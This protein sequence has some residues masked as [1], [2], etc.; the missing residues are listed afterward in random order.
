MKFNN[1]QKSGVNDSMSQKNK[2][3]WKDLGNI[4]SFE[5]TMHCM[6]SRHFTFDFYEQWFFVC[7]KNKKKEN[8]W[9]AQILVSLYWYNPQGNKS[10]AYEWALKSIR[11]ESTFIFTVTREPSAKCG[12][13]C[14]TDWGFNCDSRKIESDLK[15]PE[16]ECQAFVMLVWG[17]K[18]NSSV[19]S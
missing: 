7:Y 6:N 16:E 4:E 3:K 18:T 11:K 1:P 2:M 5:H 15:G 17:D 12:S 8:C 14:W 19:T 10:F 9:S 13:R